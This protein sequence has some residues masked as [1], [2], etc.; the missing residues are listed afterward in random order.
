MQSYLI[1]RLAPFFIFNILTEL[2]FMIALL[3]QNAAEVDFSFFPLVKTTGVLLLTTTVSFLFVML[4]YVGY[5]LL[6]P[7]KYQNSRL[8]KTIT[9]L[10]YA[11]FVFSILCEETASQIF[12]SEYS[13][14]FNF[15]AVDYL[16]YTNEMLK[17]LDQAYPVLWILAGILIAAVIIV[18]LTRRFL[19]TSIPAPKFPRRLFQSSIYAVVCILALMNIDIAK[20]EIKNPYNNE[21]AKE[22]TYSLFRSFWKSEVNYDSFYMTGNKEE[23]LRILQNILAESN[24][25]FTEPSRSVSRQISAFRTEKRANVILV[26]LNNINAGFMDENRR[27]GTEKITPN[28][29][30][31]SRG[32]LNFAKA[33]ATGTDTLH[34]IEAALLSLPPQ[35]GI[36]VIRKED[37]NSAYTLGSVFK[38][39]NYDLKF[40]YGGYGFAQN[41]NRFFHNNG[42]TVLDRPKWRKKDVVFANIWGAS[43]EDLFRKIL[44]EADNSHA[45]QKPFFTLALTLSAHYPYSYPENRIEE[46]VNNSRREQAVRYTD[47]TIGKFIEKA[48][49]KPWFDNTVFIFVGDHAANAARKKTE[50]KLSLYKIPFII[51]APGIITPHRIKTPVSQ[52][53]LAPTLL[54]LLDFSY[55]SRFYGQNVL[56]NGYTSRLFISNYQQLG[57][58]R[59]QTLITLRPVKQ[60]SVMPVSVSPQKTEKL[61]D[62]A[63]AFYQQSSELSRPLLPDGK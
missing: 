49:T 36:S 5:L 7:Q 51:Y 48:R 52:I 57:Y 54:G 44:K 2:T 21:I 10:S 22:G 26:V 28:L 42:F 62:E 24:A 43:D 1:R 55:E 56:R 30:T 38:S 37:G 31:L 45:A 59:D 27:S 8:D 61:L 19:L 47:Y 32:G 60:Y 25:V 13:S 20:L 11:F 35:P 33:Y 3:V 58:W 17:N 39:K 46:A 29:T 40:I 63:I 50:L 34:G 53:D 23:N 4:P 41:M 12:W 16:L 18:M 15:I 14:A 6:L 9:L